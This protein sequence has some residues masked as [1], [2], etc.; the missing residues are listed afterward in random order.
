[1]NNITNQTTKTI[2]YR[3]DLAS[4]A[5]KDVKCNLNCA[6][7]HKDFFPLSYIM[8]GQPQIPFDKSIKLLEIIFKKDFRKRKI[9]FTGRAEPLVIDKNLLRHT[10][11]DININFPEIEKVMTT[12]GLLLPGV[13]DILYING[14]KRINVSVHNKLFKN[15]LFMAGINA[16]K[17][18]G[19]NVCLNIVLYEDALNHFNEFL[20][21]AVI[22]KLSVKFF[23]L[24]DLD[25][26]SLI[27][28][29][30][31]IYKLLENKTGSNGHFKECKNQKVYNLSDESKIT[32]KLSEN[33][34]IRPENCNKCNYRSVCLEGC[35]ESIRITPWYIKPCGVREDNVYFFHEYS[36]YSLKKKLISGSKFILNN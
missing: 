34:N 1:M 10:L 14:I 9:H 8:N 17:N 20:N 36:S 7:C 24:L 15:S 3:I 33:T 26:E 6:Y 12:N 18:S 28:L 27:S 30:N 31:K 16:A 4:L 2:S 21:F 35:W 19:I 25:D 13:S 29:Y 5:G 11:K 22:N 23:P 32:L